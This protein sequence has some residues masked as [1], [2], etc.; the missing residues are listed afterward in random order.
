MPLVQICGDCFPPRQ[1]EA[2]PVVMVPFS[3]A[4]KKPMMWDRSELAIRMPG[5]GKRR[6]ALPMLRNGDGSPTSTKPVRKLVC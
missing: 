6:I 1:R 4:D 2:A 3:I 5:G